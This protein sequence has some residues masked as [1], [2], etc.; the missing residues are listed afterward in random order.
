MS[1]DHTHLAQLRKDLSSKNAIIPALNELSEMANDTASVEDS[2]FIEVC[3]RAFTVLNTRFSATAY[4]QAGLELFLNVQFTC[5][6]A[7][8]SLPE[9]NEWVSRALEESD[10]DAKARAKERMRASVRSKP[11]NPS[12][13]SFGHARRATSTGHCGADCTS[14]L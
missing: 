14:V 8:V 10:E 11:G 1:V 12:K 5:G 7:G 13:L 2:A 4:W 6:E 3:H 9:C